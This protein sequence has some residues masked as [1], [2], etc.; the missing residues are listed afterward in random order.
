MRK[1]VLILL[2]FLFGAFSL[3]ANN[4]SQLIEVP[5]AYTIGAKKGELI[6][7]SNFNSLRAKGIYS[8]VKDMDFMISFIGQKNI[9]SGYATFKWQF[10]HDSNQKPA[11]SIGIGNDAIYA[12]VSN[13][14]NR[15]LTGHI[16]LGAGNLS[17]IFAG[18]DYELP[19]NKDA[20]KV[21]LVAEINKSLNFGVIASIT[22][23]FNIAMAIKGFDELNIGTEFKFAF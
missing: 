20:P 14:L 13:K 21:K 7:W 9:F 22:P 11:A 15:G 16:G 17:L 8:P 3:S 18:L 1:S 5:T 12:V 6:I 19:V 2:I 10:L 23:A 4:L